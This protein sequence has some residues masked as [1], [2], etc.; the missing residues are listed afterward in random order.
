ML[1][2]ETRRA[3]SRRV[4]IRDAGVCTTPVAASFVHLRRKLTLRCGRRQ[5]SRFSPLELVPNTEL[6][7][8]SRPRA[9]PRIRETTFG[10]H[11]D[12][13]NIPAPVSCFYRCTTK[14]AREP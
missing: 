13:N 7:P 11:D 5:R 10:V 1:V 12:Y 9:R 3:S 4:G 14:Q 2:G 8:R 6:H